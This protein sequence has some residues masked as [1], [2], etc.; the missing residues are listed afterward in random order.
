MLTCTRCGSRNVEGARFCGNCGA[1]VSVMAIPNPPVWMSTPPPPMFPKPGISR[2]VWRFIGWGSAMAVGIFIL[3]V[4]IGTLLPSAS[5]QSDASQP[6]APQT[7]STHTSQATDTSNIPT[8]QESKNDKK[9]DLGWTVMKI[10]VNRT[11]TA[12]NERENLRFDSVIVM[13]D[14]VV[15]LS[16]HDAHP[17]LGWNGEP[18]VVEP[19]ALIYLPRSGGGDLL[20]V[21][22]MT[23]DFWK[24]Y[25]V[26]QQGGVDVLPGIEAHVN[27]FQQYMNDL[28]QQTKSSQQ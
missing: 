27:N 12:F 7:A 15:C 1:Q 22:D 21:N 10:A 24:R 26:H 19:N 11:P 9:E 28:E 8:P 4:I 6:S 25:C 18:A 13:P 5:N 14:D 2:A 20:A 3:L 23:L 17:L 16:I